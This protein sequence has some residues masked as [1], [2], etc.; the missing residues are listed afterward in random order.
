MI[1]KFSW[2]H[3]SDFHFRGGEDKF[4]QDVSCDAILRDIPGRLSSQYPLEFIVV[5]GDIAFSGKPHEYDLAS[6]F[7]ATLIDV[8]GVDRNRLCIVP[9]NHDVDRT[10]NKY[11]Y[12]GVRDGLTNQPVVDEFLG[13]NTDR[14][15]LMERQSAFRDFKNGLLD[16]DPIE[17]TEDG[18]ASVRL[19]NLDGFRVSV[20]ELNSAWLAGDKD[21]AG[22]LLIGERQIISALNVVDNHRAHLTIA[23]T[24]HPPDWLAEFDRLSCMSRLVPRLNIFHSGHLHWHQAHVLLAPGGSQCLHSAAGSSHETRHYRNAY[25]LVEYDV[26]NSMCRIRQ[27]EYDPVS[28]GFL[29]MA[30]I[31]YPIRSTREFTTTAADVAREL[32][33]FVPETEQ[34]AD[35]MAAL[36]LENL[37]EVPVSL[38]DAGVVLASKRLAPDFQFREVQD[39]LR[40]S[41]LIRIYDDVPVRDLISNHQTT[42]ANLVD[43]LYR[44]SSADSE[45]ADSLADRC[46]LA[47]KIAG[48]SLS[49]DSPY[50]VQ[51]LDDLAQ[52]ATLAEL[53]DAA[54]R[55]Q[56]STYREVQISANRHLAVALLRSEDSDLRQE[57]L[58]I[59]FRNLNEPWAIAGDYC[60]AAGAAESFR[61]HECAEKTALAALDNWPRD[62]HL[63]EYCRS[64]ITQ[65]GSRTLRRRLE[66]PGVDSL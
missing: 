51:H 22:N 64:L 45:F 63:R 66:E 2:L 13:Q 12:A 30:S 3:L 43:L 39:F 48:P 5:T 53:I 26:G 28:G 29:E 16:I 57:G 65:T 41:N 49:D 44:T 7:F 17:K 50:Q 54:V 27:F 55:Y 1:D 8:L 10:H 9:G 37:E 60:V 47:Q 11:T 6:A 52:S 46:A 4:S 15:L 40:I 33:N 36:L 20:L 58:R 24:H 14:N 19:L 23:L 34:F 62:P 21:Q 56:A 59:A 35:Y 18:L 42:I 25:N 61:D 38:G 32:R 31:E